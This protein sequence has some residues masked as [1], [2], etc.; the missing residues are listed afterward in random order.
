MSVILDKIV[1]VYISK[2]KILYKYRYI[3]LPWHK[4][5]SVNSFVKCREIEDMLA[6]QFSD[7]WWLARI[8]G[9]W[10]EL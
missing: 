7:F 8:I 4:F 1:Y 5:D 9:K 3:E 2:Y 6:G 10:L